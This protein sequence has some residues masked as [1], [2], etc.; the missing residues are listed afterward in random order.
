MG[1]KR[2]FLL[3]LILPLFYAETIILN[4]PSSF[5]EGIYNNTY[6][7]TTLNAV[8][9]NP[10]YGSGTYT[11]KVFNSSNAVYWQYLVWYNSFHAQPLPD[12]W[13]YE[14]GANMYG[15]VLHYHLDDTSWK[16]KD[17]SGFGNDGIA[18]NTNPHQ[19]GIFN[20]SLGFNGISSYV[21]CAKP[22]SLDLRGNLT[23]EA[24]I[25]FNETS[26]SLQNI[27]TNGHS[28]KALR[29]TGA[30]HWNG[31]NKILFELNIGG[32][33][34]LYS[35]SS[36]STNQW[37]HI[38]GTYDGSYMRLY[39][40][41]KLNNSLAVSGNVVASTVDSVVG[42]E[43][44]SA[45]FFN[46][47]IDELVV[48]NRSLSADEVRD[49]Y[50]RGAGRLNLS[51]RFCDLSDCSDGT[52]QP[53]PKPAVFDESKHKYFQF[54][55]SF[56][57]QSTRLRNVSIIFSEF[58]P[59]NIEVNE[60][61]NIN[62]STDG[63]YGTDY[64]EPYYEGYINISNNDPTKNTFSDIWISLNL[65]NKVVNY[66]QRNAL[67]LISNTTNASVFWDI[68]P[69]LIP[70]KYKMNKNGTHYIHIVKLPYNTSVVFKYIVNITNNPILVEEYYY[71]NKIIANAQQEWQINLTISLNSNDTVPFN[72]TKILR[73]SSTWSNLSIKNISQ[74]SGDVYISN[75]S[76]TGGNGSL[77]WE[78]ITL[79]SSHNQTWILFNVSGYNNITYT[80]DEPFGFGSVIFNLN[81]TFSGSGVVDVSSI[82]PADLE[83][84]KEQN[85]SNP[86][87]WFGKGIVKN[88]AG[89]VYYNVSLLSVWAT[90]AGIQ[91]S[92]NKSIIS[93]S[94]NES[95][96]GIL[97]TNKEKNIST[98]FN[99]EGVP[100]V[101]SNISFKLINNE[102]R[103]YNVV[104]ISNTSY[105][106]S[107]RI[108]VVH[109]YLI[110]VTKHVEHVNNNTYDVYLV[111][112]NIGSNNSPYVY[113]YDLIPN[114]YTISNIWVNQSSMLA[115]HANKNSSLNYTGKNLDVPQEYQ[116][117][118]YWAL[119][120]IT[121]QANG[122]GNYEDG[123]EIQNNQTVII[124][125]RL[126][127]N[128]AYKHSYVYV[129]GID[130]AHSLLSTTTNLVAIVG[131]LKEKNFENIFILIFSIVSVVL[132]VEAEKYYLL[133]ENIESEESF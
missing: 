44:A 35:T 129:I 18:S 4:S 121:K 54:K 130:P 92:P 118:Y 15:A 102:T 11:S 120:P 125:Y 106:I 88:T 72:Y 26:N 6:Y 111:V 57:N 46:G 52:W 27:F 10:S 87:E 32:D 5:N 40:D 14:E 127:G 63:V 96:M 3:L 93:G 128:G 73:N 117:S 38:V 122:D 9:L 60:I 22:S 65:T 78:N 48:Y 51:V 80:N 103:G 53:Y 23:Y 77:H 50:E 104:N 69:S 1:P 42:A 114:N 101:W 30:T 71:P 113:I 34:Q 84:T 45:Y 58:S 119:M 20:Y 43:S 2:L 47:T 74:E 67:I 29:V 37:H 24:W 86:Q 95:Q 123:T 132:F 126:T 55:F 64:S 110:K 85:V 61:L 25:K 100:I 68:N 39:V 33:R 107:E 76:Y 13:N 98:K 116:S 70:S 89:V 19:Q 49:H 66:S 21:N 97:E 108:Y 75:S 83:I 81:H 79:N 36:L 94:K 62:A 112:E 56:Y 109:G 16:I 133:K 90:K 82:G 28:Q 41:G 124:H 91:A 115:M 59:L 7:N 12:H 105:S 131:G 99:Y 17:T 31:A 8:V